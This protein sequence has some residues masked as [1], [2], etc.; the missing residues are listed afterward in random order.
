MVTTAKRIGELVTELHNVL[1]SR[2]D[3]KI[4]RNKA[5]VKMVTKIYEAGANDNK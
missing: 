2:Y 1:N 5:I 4:D 3:R